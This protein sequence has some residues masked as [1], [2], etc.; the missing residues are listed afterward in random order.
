MHYGLINKPLLETRECLVLGIFA[1]QEL[2]A[3]GLT[4]NKEHDNLVSKL[5]KRASEPGDM[6]WQTDLQGH[7]LVVI[8]CGN[9]DEFN[10]LSLQKRVAEITEAL[11]KQRFS[12]A[13]FCFPVLTAEKAEWQLEQMIVQIDNLRYQMLDFKKKRAKAHRLEAIDF[14][15]PGATEKNTQHCQSHC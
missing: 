4:L 8:Q 1:D 11:I 13:T 2:P 12:S 15:L 5:A 10:A 9:K 14:Y 7:S 6:A 3:Y